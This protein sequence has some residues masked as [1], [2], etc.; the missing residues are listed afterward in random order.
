MRRALGASW[1]GLLL[2]VLLALDGAV[3]SL[4]ATSPNLF[5]TIPSA[6]KLALPRPRRILAT[7]SV[8]AAQILR[9]GSASHAL[10]ATGDAYSAPVFAHAAGNVLHHF[11]R[12]APSEPRASSEP[13]AREDA[14]GG[15]PLTRALIS[16]LL[17]CDLSVDGED[18]LSGP[19]LGA[20]GVIH[21]NLPLLNSAQEVTLSH[22]AHLFFNISTTRQTLREAGRDPP[23]LHEVFE[24]LGYAGDSRQEVSAIELQL[25]E[26]RSRAAY[27]KLFRHNLGLIHHELNT[28]KTCTALERA[29]MWQEGTL[30]LLRAI[31]Y[32]RPALDPPLHTRCAVRG[33]RSHPPGAHSGAVARPSARARAALRRLFDPARKVRFS[34]YACWHI[35]AHIL[36]ALRDKSHML[37]LPQP[38]QDDMK[39]VR[40]V[41]RRADARARARRPKRARSSLSDARCADPSASHAI[42]LFPSRAQATAH[43]TMENDGRRPSS[44]LVAEIL[45]WPESRVER[46]LQGFS[47]STVLALVAHRID[48][49]SGEW[50]HGVAADSI[51]SASHGIGDAEVAILKEQFRN[52]VRKVQEGREPEHAKMLALRYGLYD[53]VE[54]STKQIAERFHVTSQVV[55][56][57][58]RKE[59][60]YLQ[61]R[62]ED[63]SSFMQPE[64]AELGSETATRRRE[65][66]TRAPAL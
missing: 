19:R 14:F 8:G 55:Y 42:L 54:W 4:Q 48:E 34:T 35:R 18:L 65:T 44:G 27:G 29:D 7:R 45:D 64:G 66:R 62:H 58:I 33:A 16:S 60:K 51:T 30:G 26:V 37:R 50:Q 49:S 52:S 21:A 61:A 57:I 41:G 43:L 17:E 5:I 22:F 28:H 25:L 36:H 32:A 56:K 3:P 24:T 23:S 10:A 39:Q 13:D 15:M 63:F 47:R 59:V 11:G 38:L 1:E 46:A 20:G 31:Q 9:T 6:P 2:V 12:A 40:K 53:G